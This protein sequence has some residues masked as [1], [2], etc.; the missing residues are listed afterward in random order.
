MSKLAW[1]VVDNEWTR[2]QRTLRARRKLDAQ[3]YHL[4]KQF[5]DGTAPADCVIACPTEYDA[6]QLLE[7]MKHY[8]ERLT[9]ESTQ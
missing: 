1:S 5:V 7:R 2:P 6:A 8:I 9:S 3:A 4:A